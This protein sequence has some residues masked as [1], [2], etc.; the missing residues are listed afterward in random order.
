M[1]A[2][3]DS[4]IAQYKLATWWDKQPV[5]NE[6]KKKAYFDWLTYSAEGED[7]LPEAM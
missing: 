2:I 6:I 7:G 1:A 4:K 3:R 5:N